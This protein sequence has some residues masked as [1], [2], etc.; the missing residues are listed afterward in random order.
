MNTVFIGGS[1]HF[2]R[3][4]AEVKE[5]MDNVLSGGLRVIVGDANG[6]DKAVQKYL[7]DSHHDD[8]TVFCSGETCRNNLGGWRT[9]NID[10][11]KSAKGFQFYATK[12][13]EM[14]READFGL[15]IWD[16]KSAGTLLNVLRL[17]RADKK[18]V[19]FNVPDKRVTTF[20]SSSDWDNFLSECSDELRSDLRERATS[21]EWTPSIPIQPSLLDIESAPIEQT[22]PKKSDAEL[23][24]Q[25]NAALAA[26]DPG[27]VL[28]AL[29]HFA[30]VRGM[31]QVAKRTGLAREGLYRALSTEGN[32]EFATVLKVM[33]SLGLHL[34]ATPTSS[35]PINTLGRVQTSGSN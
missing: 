15:M 4:P 2:S 29:G 35:E 21:D 9:N 12:D 19:L 27:T 10:V 8:V 3:L 30:R 34:T 22:P 13:R 24:G 6:A 26:G 18:A 7:L 28:D 25:L 5:R 23:E 14:A 20:K 1:R 33:A 16:G 32:P 17:L 31:S 11:P